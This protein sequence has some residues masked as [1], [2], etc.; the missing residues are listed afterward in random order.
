MES[1]ADRSSD[2]DSGKFPIHHH[3]SFEINLN[4]LIKLTVIRRRLEEVAQFESQVSQSFTNLPNIIPNKLIDF[5]ASFSSLPPPTLPA[6][7]SESLNKNLERIVFF[8]A[9]ARRVSKRAEL[10]RR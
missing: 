4:N 5:S 10:I 6:I 2:S 8:F 7:E 3:H 9:S 1:S